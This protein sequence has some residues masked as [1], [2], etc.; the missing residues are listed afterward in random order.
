MNR[1]ILVG[2]LVACGALPLT[3]AGAQTPR[4]ELD[5]VFIVVTPGAA[6]ERAAL[7]AAGLRV[8]SQPTRHEGQGTASVAAFFGNAYLELIWVDSS[9]AVDLD[10]AGTLNWF[11]KATAW[12]SNGS[13]PFG[14]G[15]RRVPG[16]TA[17]LPVPTKREPV[18]GAATGVA[19]ELLH[20]P[21]DTL[22]ADFFVVPPG[23]A[24]PA[25]IERARARVPE[26]FQHPRGGREITGVRVYGRSPHEPA[27][28]RVLHPGGI[29]MV[30]SGDVLLEIQ[31][32]G[33]RRGERVD[34]RP[35]LPVVLL[36]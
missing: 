14:L 25:W 6:A 22:A 31:I 30:A 33:G 36:R 17:P 19:Y 13:S 28:F 20:Q 29:E 15:L 35:V 2:C 11:Q 1:S 26:L 4:V 5:H 32:D 27:A 21:A 12:R 34:L 16:D 18:P 24:V 10:R 3:L 8:D 23:N 9:V 7:S